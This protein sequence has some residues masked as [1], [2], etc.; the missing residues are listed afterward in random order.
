MS[1]A[2]ITAFS[3]CDNAPTARDGNDNIA[4]R[5]ISTLSRHGVLGVWHWRVWPP[6]AGH[7]G[8]QQ[9]EQSA[10]SQANPA[11]YHPQAG[12]MAD[13]WFCQQCCRPGRCIRQAG[14]RQGGHI[15]QADNRKRQ[16]SP[17]TTEGRW[18]HQA[19]FST[20]A[21]MHVQCM[22]SECCCLCDLQH[23]TAGH[24]SCR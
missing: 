7:P 16:G 5:G 6:V 13:V 20:C 18:S 11:A 17:K 14:V 9:Q 21:L 12:H 1:Y 22:Y 4:T 15:Q 3:V 8:R 10:H 24:S 23:S 2:K 19:I